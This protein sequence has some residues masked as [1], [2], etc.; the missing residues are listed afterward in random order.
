MRIKLDIPFSLSKIK[1]A[2]GA[3]VSESDENVII[4]C[5]CTDTRQIGVGDLFFALPG[6]NFDGEDFIEE[7]I[8]KG[9]FTVSAKSGLADV[10]VKDCIKALLSLAYEYKKQLP[11]KRTVVI[12]GSVGKTTTKELLHQLTKRKY[13]THA[14]VGNLNN[15]I[16][17]PFTVL[18]AP[19]DTEILIIEAGMNHKG[20]LKE[21]SLSV[22]PDI[23]IITKIGTSH[24]GNFGSRKLIAEAKTEIT[25]NMNPFT[26]RVIIPYGEPLLD[27]ITTKKTVSTID[28]GADFLFT[29]LQRDSFKLLS[30]KYRSDD[31]RI[32]LDASHLTECLAFALATCEELD[33]TEEEILD[34]IKGLQKTNNSAKTY[35]IDGITLIDD[36][37]NSSLESVRAA[38][39]TLC[40]TEGKAKCVCIGDILELGTHTERIHRKIGE[41]CHCYGLDKIYTFGVYSEFVAKGAADAGFPNKK[42]YKNSDIT[43]PEI[44]AKQIKDTAMPG[45]VV[46]FKGS[47]KLNLTRICEILLA[48]P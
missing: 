25:Y 23:A 16:G 47:H 33:F 43:R 28:S 22:K 19:Y 24:I 2:L 9:A 15:M 17:V 46:L 18:S 37:Y 21:I 32:S 3:K 45:D 48:T 14:T 8:S 35:E 41:L 13:K 30:Q 38:L 34:A 26:K 4:D 40:V 5:I 7:A 36:S 6:E 39:E 42:I 27:G 1:R 20:E 31:I 29:Q 10:L 11:I 44:T 12:T